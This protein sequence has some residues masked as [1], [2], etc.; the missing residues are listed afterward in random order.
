M[1][2]LLAKTISKK[3]LGESL[4]NKFGKEDPYF[5]QVP[6]TRLDGRP[7]GKV[8]KRKKAL[9]PGISEHDGQVLTKVKRRAYRLDMC[10][11][12][13][14]G[15][16]FGWSSVIGLIPAAGDAL[17]AFMA[18]MVYRTCCQVEGGLP[19]AVRVKMLINI[20]LDFAVGLVPFLGDLADAV[21]RANTRN[22]ALLE[23]HLR[24][25]GKKEL[26]K[27]GQPIPAIDPSSAEEY[28][29]IQREDP[30][31]ISQTPRLA[32]HLRPGLK[33]RSRSPHERQIEFTMCADILAAAR[34]AHTTLRWARYT[35]THIIAHVKPASKRVDDNGAS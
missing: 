16:R 31:S 25:K 11:F 35:E 13:F 33:S 8:K 1:T 3:I 32:D 6:A 12:N 5:E 23:E 2:S 19:T 21:F 24:Q 14:L 27:S 30:R 15:I 29:R 9:P 34:L 28:D 20:I 4:Q 17:D 22:A 26:R 18:F 10:L 7:T